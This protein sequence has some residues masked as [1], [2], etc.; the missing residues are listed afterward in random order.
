VEQHEFEIEIRPDGK[1][2]VHIKGVKGSACLE[3]AKLFEQIAHGAGQA[4]HTH[5]FYEP[6]TDVRIDLEQKTKG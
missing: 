6:P 2:M 1:I 3:Y 5:E 4:Q